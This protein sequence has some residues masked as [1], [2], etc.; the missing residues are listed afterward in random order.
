MSKRG[1]GIIILAAVLAMA[2]VSCT[3]PRAAVQSLPSE[4][5]D[6]SLVQGVLPNGFQ[7]LVMKNT[8]PKERVSVH[9]NVFAGSVNEKENEQGVAHFL[10][11]ML[12]NGSEHFKPGELITYFQSIGMDFGAD[13]NASTSFFSTVY[14]LNLPKGD[15]KHLEEGFL[16]IKDYAGGALLLQSEIDRE[17][18]V[19][20]AEKRERDSVSYRT[21]E[22]ELGF[23]FPGSL[24]SRRLP[25][26]KDEVIRGA[27]RDIFKSFYDRWYRPDNMALVVV[28]DVDPELVVRLVKETFSSL[29]P[30]SQEKIDRQPDIAWTARKGINPCY[31][32][33]P[34]AGNTEITLERIK[35]NPFAPET[36]ESLEEDVVRFLGDMMLDNRLSKMVREQE[37]DF[38]RV[39]VYSGSYLR[40][41]EISAVQASCEPGRW[42]ASLTQLETG[43]RQAVDYGFSVRELNRVK[44]DY[45]STLESDLAGRSTRESTRLA[46][47]ILSALNNGTLFL[48]PEQRLEILKPFV[49]NLGVERVNAAFKM[50]WQ[51]D[52]R[53][54]MVTGNADLGSRGAEKIRE[55]YKTA[56][57]T[58]LA[59][60]KTAEAK[61][62]PYLALPDK[63][64][65]MV[66]EDRDVNGLG[67]TRA[68]FDNQIRL[69][70]KQ[71][72]FKKGE[73]R[74]KAVFGNGRAGIPEE[75]TG[76]SSLAESLVEESGLGQMDLDQLHAALAGKDVSIGFD[77]N[78]SDF[79]LEGTAST[80]EAELV[81]QLL[82]AYLAD[83][84]FRQ[85]GLALAKSRYRQG[86]EAMKRTPEGIMAIRGQPFLAGGDP[87]FG[88]AP[89][90]TAE[91]ITLP[92][93]ENWL[94]P[95]FATAPLEVSVTG[96][97]NMDQV[98]TA[99]RVYLGALAERGIPEKDVLLKK[100]IRFPAGR[101]LSLNLATKIDKGVVRAVFKTDDYW[102]IM[103][104][105]KLS[106]LSRVFSERLRKQIREA[107]GASYSP[108]VYNDPSLVFKHY[109]VMQAVV[110]TSPDDFD[111]VAGQM[112]KI[113]SSLCREG[114]AEKELALVKAPVMSHLK[115]LRRDNGYWLNSVMSD[116]FRHPEKLDWAGHLIEGYQSITADELS[117]MARRYLKTDDSALILIRP[118]STA[119][120]PSQ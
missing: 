10:E 70:L 101:S 9:L 105:R 90:K 80:K 117:A 51:P 95:Q 86:Y 24:L 99:A 77:I 113:A 118:A 23:E 4:P 52:H 69:N 104:T 110:S 60:Y 94:R 102:D 87:W 56:A 64:A 12:F 93:I 19:I 13:A 26:G 62:F 71:T 32:Y 108:Y 30:R 16:V 46:R 67:I 7:Y 76:L 29:K 92:M 91:N 57:G 42:Q 3:V 98:L 41:A 83:P 34:E 45:I 72:D 1:F 18:G 81:F 55:V 44:A 43:L 84:G 79:S 54:V 85:S 14:D 22:E 119:D 39:D 8:R 73:F 97:F 37:A 35:Y 78:A 53:L 27:N 63:K 75:L 112:K 89:P 20:L 58:P 11:H 47:S 28:G 115:E 61:A 82:Y 36:L 107:L 74:F 5:R 114:V 48:S 109:G 40:N 120:Q 100:E 59:A 116:S 6:P 49:E 96:D 38:T 15:Q 88:I 66:I 21:F 68:V 31:L 17:R 2:L 103:Q 25:I 65:A 111:L 106:L 33:E 50:S